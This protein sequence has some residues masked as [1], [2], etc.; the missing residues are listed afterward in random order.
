MNSRVP[1]T[2]ARDFEVYVDCASDMHRVLDLVS[3]PDELPKAPG[4]EVELL[5]GQVLVRVQRFED[6]EPD[7]GAR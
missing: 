1:P 4:E 7:A 5:L 3:V 6:G 2:G